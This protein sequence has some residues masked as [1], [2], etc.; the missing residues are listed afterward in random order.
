MEALI[1]VFTFSEWNISTSLNTLQYLLN[2]RY[3]KRLLAPIIK[4]EGE[5]YFD[6]NDEVVATTMQTPLLIMMNLEFANVNKGNLSP[7]G[8]NIYYILQCSEA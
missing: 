4:F 6:I 8:I 7:Q 1:V 2:A 5:N 3:G